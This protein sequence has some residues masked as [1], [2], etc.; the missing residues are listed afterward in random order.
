MKGLTVHC[1]PFVSVYAL[2][3]D[4]NVLQLSLDQGTFA[5]RLAK[6]EGL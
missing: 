1:N 3:A 4:A 6:V 5:E 2:G